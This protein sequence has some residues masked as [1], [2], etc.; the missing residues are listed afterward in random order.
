MCIETEHGLK[1]LEKKLQQLGVQVLRPNVNVQYP[2]HEKNRFAPPLQPRNIMMMIGNKFYCRNTSNEQ[3]QKY[4]ANIADA[5][6]DRYSSVHE[7]LAH[8][9]VEQINEA[10]DQFNLA[11]EMYAFAH[12]RDSYGD[13]IDFVK[14]QGNQI[15]EWEMSE[16]ALVN[17]IGQD[18]Y[19]GTMPACRDLHKLQT[20]YDSE[21]PNYRNHMI[22]SIGHTDGVFCA[23]RPGLIVA[24]DD[25]DL[26]I[27][28]N[29]YFPDWEV[30]YVPN[31]NPMAE[32]NKQ[33][34][35]KEFF[36][37]T[38][39]RWWWPGHENDNELIDLVENNFDSWIGS[40]GESVFDVNMLVVDTKNVIT[41]VNNDQLNS[42][43]EKY[44]ITVHVIDISQMYFWDGG[45]HCITAD[46]DRVGQKQN[47]F[48]NRT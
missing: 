15:V 35:H 37:K 31:N 24:Y 29:R 10:Y 25:P 18:L 39:N 32:Y 26:T 14:Q 36:H 22:D 40:S 42:K 44:G 48:P 46:L 20:T 45:A 4:Y 13:I 47:Y 30:I 33:K 3:W 38:R 43:L 11:E 27:D 23:V 9:P 1:S 34:E 7:F 17:R 12:H 2:V 16:G 21:F 41:L 6:W 8:A 5:S 28:Y 19:F